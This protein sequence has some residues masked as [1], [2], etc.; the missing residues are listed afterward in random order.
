M[1]KLFLLIGLLMT[2]L[3]VSAQQ[4]VSGTVIDNEGN[5]IPGAKVEIVGS[6]EMC[7]TELDGTYR[8]ETLV[9]AKKVKVQYAGMRTA[10]KK[11]T[12]DMVVELSNTNWWNA[13]PDK[14]RWLLSLQ[15]AFP[16]WGLFN[17]SLGL[18]VGRVKNIGWYVKGVYS[19]RK[20]TDGESSGYYAWTTG[21]ENRSF[22]AITGGVIVRLGCPIYFYGGMGYANRQIAWELVDGSWIEIDGE[23]NFYSYERC[24]I[25]AGTMIELGINLT[26]N[27][28]TMMTAKDLKSQM[29]CVGCVGV[30]YCF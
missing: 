4:T 14:Y 13:K 22:G 19:P 10:V 5:P 18:M 26:I 28:G 23:R 17:P 11:I 3:I 6:T 8:I 20:S 15:G 27:I 21:D 1:R 9:P 7:I 2:S 24:A 29:D 25:E 30:G 12:P 16:E